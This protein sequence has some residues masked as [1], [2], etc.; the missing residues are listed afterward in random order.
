MSGPGNP[1]HRLT[2]AGWILLTACLFPC[3]ADSKAETYELRGTIVKADDGKPVKGSYPTIFLRSV[4]T[5]FTTSTLAGP[6]G[7]FTFKN[8][9][10]SPYRLTIAV[11]RWGQMEKS[12]DIGP[13]FADRKNRIE[14]EFRFTPDY[15]SDEYD[16]VSLKQLVIPDQALKQYQEALKDLEK[17]KNAQAVGHLEEAVRIAPHYS[18]AWN[19]L[20]TIS[21]VS[22]EFSRA[23]TCFRTAVEHDPNSFSPVVNLGAALYA[24]GKIEESLLYNLKAVSMEP[25]DPLANS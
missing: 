23:E 17:K 2:L 12:I 18:D 16:V 15:R 4:T 22:S 20:G 21:F 24:L 11:P 9:S 10:P 5:P 7:K 3:R 6:S 19:R 1:L 14:M 13:S 8:L 25:G